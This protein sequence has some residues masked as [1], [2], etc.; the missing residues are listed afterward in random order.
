MSCGSIRKSE[1]HNSILTCR[2]YGLVVKRI[3]HV[4]YRKLCPVL[5]DPDPGKIQE[6]CIF[7][8]HHNSTSMSNLGYVS[9]AFSAQKKKNIFLQWKLSLQPITRRLV[10][11]SHMQSQLELS[12]TSATWYLTEVLQLGSCWTRMASPK[13]P[14]AA[15]DYQSTTAQPP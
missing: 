12:D 3:G 8:A 2:K 1:V 9:C 13:F 4:G 7:P 14:N 10:C 5:Y 15:L 11:W 6:I